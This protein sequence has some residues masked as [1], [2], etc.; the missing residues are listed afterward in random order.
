MDAS[1]TPWSIRFDGAPRLTLYLSE[2]VRIDMERIGLSDR[3]TLEVADGVDATVLVGSD[4][5]NVQHFSIEPGA[6]I[7]AHVHEN[8]QLGFMI[9]GRVIVRL[10]DDEIELTAGDSYL[11]RPNEPHS[12]ENPDEEPAVGI[13]VFNPPR[14][15]PGWHPEADD[16]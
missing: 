7:P 4:Q 1:F 8:E 9:S 10:P 2:T 5:M 11:I 15:V 16:E 14:S 3:E 6:K 12:A 13:D